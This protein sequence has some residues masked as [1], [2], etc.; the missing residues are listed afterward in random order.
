[1]AETAP[2]VVTTTGYAT[3]LVIWEDSALAPSA[4]P[5]HQVSARIFPYNY[6]K[7]ILYV[8]III[9]L[10]YIGSF[11]IH[12]QFDNVKSEYPC[13][14]SLSDKDFLTLMIIHHQMALD[15]SIQHV[16]NTK[17]DI[18]MK[19][20]REL[21]WTQNYEILLMTEEL[22]HITATIS[23]IHVNQPFIPFISSLTYPNEIGLSNTYC[24]PSFFTSNE[25]RQHNPTD[26]KLTDKQYILHMIP[27]HQV[28]I[29]MCKMLLKHTKSDFLIYL[30]YKMIREQESENVLLSDLLKSPMLDRYAQHSFS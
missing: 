4:V 8:L 13:R 28:A 21:I 22:K 19:I 25:H 17:N 27:H 23:E 6:S 3:I 16:K 5:L 18:I 11:T 9:F 26:E 1:V 24:D 20:L 10:L 2:L 29:D 30:A 12:E 7:M 15:I 14:V